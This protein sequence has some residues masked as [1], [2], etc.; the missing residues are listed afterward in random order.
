MSEQNS[1][2]LATRRLD[3][4]TSREVEAYLAG[5][6]DL[7]FVPFGPISGH[8][9]FIPLGI[10]AHWAEALGKLLAQMANGLLFPPVH[11]CYAGATQT[12][13]GT[14]SY[15]IAEQA[16]TLVRTARLL[17]AQ[18]FHRT[19][20]IAGTSPEIMGGTFAARELF[21]QTGHPFWCIEA[22]RLLDHPEV[23]SMWEGYS[24][25]FGETVIGL[26]SLKILGRERPIPMAEW[27]REPKRDDGPDQPA[28]IAGDVVAL[29]RW[30]A[31]GFRYY[32]EGHHGNHGTAG[33]ECN[34]MNDIDLA[35]KTLERCA[36][37][38]LPSLESL[39]RYSQWTG[40]HG[41]QYIR[42]QE[43]L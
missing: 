22:A 32:S 24:G 42:A 23:K 29:R 41:F 4:M 17:H 12:F 36:Q 34:G 3:E 6:G 11:C 1:T 43:R 38:L 10:H 20:L 30:G 18:G 7:I 16:A 2:A 9:A 15:T 27:A 40:T 5:G 35:V 28:D 13:R 33:I 8:G 37:L 31:V 26:A 21:D 25:S 19:V 14:V 39:T